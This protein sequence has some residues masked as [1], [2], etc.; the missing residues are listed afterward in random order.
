MDPRAGLEV[1]EKRIILLSAGNRAPT[2]Q[3]V[4]RHLKLIYECFRIHY[5]NICWMDINVWDLGIWLQRP[6]HSSGG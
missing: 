3:P 5:K 2:V 1:V 6:R 4:A